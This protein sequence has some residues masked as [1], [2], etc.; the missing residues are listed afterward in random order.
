MSEHGADDGAPLPR[1][2]ASERQQQCWNSIGVRGDG[3]CPELERHVHCRNCPVH[4]AAA[5]QLLLRAA[6]VDDMAA[7]TD[8]YAAEPPA[9]AGARAALVFRVGAEWFGLSCALL[10]EIAESRPR[11]ALPHRRSGA[12]LGLVNVRGELLP[13]VAIAAVLGATEAH[14]ARGA[15]GARG[16][17]GAHGRLL[18]LKAGEGPQQGRIACPVDEVHGVLRFDARELQSPPATVTRAAA[19]Y[20]QALLPWRQRS[21]GLL[22]EPLLLY[23][24]ARSLA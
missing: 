21:V 3:S 20:T 8:R 7:A 13:A 4:A 19:R 22:D 6:P 18:V 2:F 12:L 11:H 14:A 9:P 10:D 23:T 24:L 15:E 5:R 17:H 16:T 1:H